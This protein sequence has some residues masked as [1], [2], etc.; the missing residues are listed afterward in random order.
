MR[1]AFY[2]VLALGFLARL[3]PVGLHLF[4]YAV[5]RVHK[6]LIP[7]RRAFVGLHRGRLSEIPHA[8]KF[9]ARAI[10]RKCFFR[11]PGLFLVKLRRTFNFIHMA[12]L[13]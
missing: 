6:F 3:A 11:L 2:A 1:F 4:P 10:G 13:L 12:R 8:G 5:E 9:Q 7:R